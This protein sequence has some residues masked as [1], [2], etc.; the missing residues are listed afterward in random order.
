M[1]KNQIYQ[2]YVEGNNEKKMASVLKSEYG[3]IIAGKIEKLNIVEKR[4]TNQKLM[5]LK[6]DTIVILVFD[7]DT[8]SSEI[9]DENLRYLE[10]QK[11]IRAVYCVTQVRN[12]EDEL[13]KS[14]N[15]V[16]IKEL[17]GSKTNKEFKSDWQR[18]TNLRQRLDT[19]EFDFDKFWSSEAKGAFKHIENEADKVK[20]RAK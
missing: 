17:T 15:I 10:R 18:I 13:K 4:I 19:K 11:N 7:T 12:L 14:C 16:Q 3:H 20:V 2:Y 1:S 9:L 8:E 6:K 5:Q